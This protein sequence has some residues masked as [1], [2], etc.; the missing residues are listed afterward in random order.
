MEIKANN[1]QS[2]TGGWKVEF[3]PLRP[4]RTGQEL[5]GI[6]GQG[7]EEE[8]NIFASPR[9]WVQKLTSGAT[10]QKGTIDWKQKTCAIPRTAKRGNPGSLGFGKTSNSAWYLEGL[11]DDL[12]GETTRKDTKATPT[13]SHPVHDERLP[14]RGI[15]PEDVTGTCSPMA[16]NNT[17]FPGRRFSSF[18]S[19]LYSISPLSTSSFLSTSTGC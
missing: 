10:L 3:Q 2:R 5:Y 1:E 17:Q 12:S 4:D 13:D 8:A 11:A 18:S 14:Q 6:A 16:I 9:V 7:A 19:F 15:G